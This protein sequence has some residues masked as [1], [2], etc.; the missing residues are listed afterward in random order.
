MALQILNG[1]VSSNVADS[2]TFTVSYPTNLNAGHFS[3]SVAHVMVV[4]QNTLAYPSKF[5]LTF[6]S[7]NITVTNKTGST[8]AANTPYILQ[9]ETIGETQY[10]NEASG[11]SPANTTRPVMLECQLGAP[12][13]ASSTFLATS[14]SV[15]AA[16]SFVLAATTLD[17]PRNVVAAWTTASVLT[18][19]GTDV[20]GVAMTESNASGTSFTGKKAFKTITSIVSSASITAATAG[21]GAVL[22]LPFFLPT[23]GHV[24]TRMESGAVVT[25][26]T[27]VA[28]AATAVSTATTG[29]VRGTWAPN[30]APDGSVTYTV[31][32]ACPDPGYR[33]VTQA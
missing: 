2:G 26:G 4:G 33:G 14:Q 17:V 28:G 15:A 16:G 11:F 31:I 19:T 7:S 22:G 21:T 24:I 10:T 13:A 25:N 30:T 3:A 9:L 1:S 5:T 32:A 18:V 29:D 20:Y 8:W 23:T 27:L 12:A 6:G